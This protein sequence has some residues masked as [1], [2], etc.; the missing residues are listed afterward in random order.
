MFR[1]RL[2]NYCDSDPADDEAR[3]VFEQQ[4]RSEF[5]SEVDGGTG[6]PTGN[7]FNWAV[8]HMLLAKNERQQVLSLVFYAMVSQLQW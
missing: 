3:E 2:R 1:F 5:C 6:L 4:G 7:N 8:L